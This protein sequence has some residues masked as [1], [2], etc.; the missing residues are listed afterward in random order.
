M[1]DNSYGNETGW[2]YYSNAVGT[3]IGSGGGASAYE[4]QPGYQKGV[5]A[6]G[7]RTTPDVSLVADPS[8]GA[9]IADPY[10]L[11]ADNPFEVVGG[12][13]LSAPSWAGLIA[14][15][16]Q[17]RVAAGK[18]TL[19]SNGGTTSQAALYAA[20]ASSFNS[21]TSGTNGGYNAAAGYNLV[22]GL[23]T[24]VADM[25]LPALIAFDGIAAPNATATPGQDSGDGEV[26][27]HECHGGIQRVQRHSRRRRRPHHDAVAL[28]QGIGAGTDRCDQCERS[29]HASQRR[30]AWPGCRAARAAAE[31]HAQRGTAAGC[32]QRLSA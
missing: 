17:G 28:D 16:N 14:L 4:P 7:Y 18:T 11:S 30:G 1:R 22:T 19:S 6:T 3:F 27:Q 29:A 24:P 20:P 5:Q 23:G 15:V 25:L 2:G 9:W 12:T 10:N 8:T 21:I 32:R 13:S 31:Q 26:G